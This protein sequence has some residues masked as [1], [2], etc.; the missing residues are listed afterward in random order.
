VICE[1][2][3][4]LIIQC[5][6]FITETEL[7]KLFDKRAARTKKSLNLKINR[8]HRSIDNG[9]KH[10]YIQKNNTVQFA[11]HQQISPIAINKQL[12]CQNGY[13]EVFTFSCFTA[14]FWNFVIV[15]KVRSL[16]IRKREE[17]DTEL[18]PNGR[19]YEKRTEKHL[20]LVVLKSIVHNSKYETHTGMFVV[21][22][23]VEH[24]F[25]R[26][27]ICLLPRGS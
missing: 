12:F 23:P 26:C 13:A 1:L 19:C 2:V 15:P 18:G 4:I 22:C 27:L 10:N 21:V 17:F 7:I 3:C 5:F 24:T 11:D 8:W 9:G 6:K 14:L 16:K 25:F 20:N